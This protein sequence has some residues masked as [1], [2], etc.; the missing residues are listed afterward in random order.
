MCYKVILHSFILGKSETR[1]QDPQPRPKNQASKNRDP[2]KQN[3]KNQN[4]K[5]WDPKNKNLKNWH[6]KILSF[7]NL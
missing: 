5:N 6:Y 1:T 7:F 2:K 4:P 3:P